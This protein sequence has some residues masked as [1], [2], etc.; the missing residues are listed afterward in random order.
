MRSIHFKLAIGTAL[1]GLC[2]VAASAQSPEPQT[3]PEGSTQ[4]HGQWRGQRGPERELEMLTR[5]LSL[6]PE[7]QTSVKAVLEQQRSQMIALRAKSQTDS[8]NADT[9]E[10][11]QA[12]ITQMNQIHDESDTKIAALLDDNQKKTFAGWVAKR[13]AAMAQRQGQNGASTTAPN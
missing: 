8:A 3:L 2:S 7:Q 12:R 6:T 11:R 10:A 13:K 9:P 5:R 1:L 4:G